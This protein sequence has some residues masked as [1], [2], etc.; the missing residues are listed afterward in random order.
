MPKTLPLNLE[1]RAARIERRLARYRA[2]TLVL[3]IALGASV[4]M[5][6]TPDPLRVDDPETIRVRTL[7]LVDAEGRTVGRL[8]APEG[9]GQLVLNDAERGRIV[10][11]GAGETRFAVESTTGQ[12][13]LSFR[14]RD[15]GTAAFVLRPREG[16]ASSWL[17]APAKGSGNLYLMDGDKTAVHLGASEGGAGQVETYVDNKRVFYA[18]SNASTKKG[19]VKIYGEGGRNAV[20]LY[21]NQQSNQG[22]VQVFGTEHRLVFLGGS[23]TSDGMLT[24]HDGNGRELVY[25]GSNTRGHGLVRVQAKEG[26]GMGAL[27]VDRDGSGDILVRDAEG[28]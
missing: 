2:A 14:E 6:A 8:H 15:G 23:H 1:E 10:L 26:K 9:Q 27:F 17:Q 13:L 4:W 5:S 25:A 20:D 28:K 19:L 18:G 12:S 16:D 22:T 7:E 11:G 24:V 21:A 3:T